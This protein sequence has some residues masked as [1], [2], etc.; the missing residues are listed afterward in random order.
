MYVYNVL[1]STY[2]LF[3]RTKSCEKSGNVYTR[4]TKDSLSVHCIAMLITIKHY[5]HLYYWSHKHVP[6]SYTSLIYGYKIGLI[7]LILN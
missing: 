4:R 5:N 6:C 1:L 7:F 3:I 2:N